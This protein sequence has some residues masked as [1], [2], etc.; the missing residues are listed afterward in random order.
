M[1]RWLKII[2][3]SVLAVAGILIATPIE[4]HPPTSARPS[5][6]SV[7]PQ[8]FVVSLQR[9]LISVD[10]HATTALHGDIESLVKTMQTGKATV[11]GSSIDV[12]GVAT[13]N[14]NWAATLNTFR[15]NLPANVDLA[16]D[17]FVVDESLRIDSLCHKI[18]AA[19][20]DGKI[21]FRQSSSEL[22][23]SSYAALDRLISFARDCR[24]IAIQITGHSDA[25]GSVEF[26]RALSQRRAQAVAD[27]LHRGGISLDRLLVAGRGAEE[28]I[29]DN[30]TAH[31]RGR[32]RRIEFSILPLP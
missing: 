14:G 1:P 17:V 3:L 4:K 6:L 23:R 7:P 21:G 22:R 20:S 18:F 9:G 13:I 11:S 31:G 26:N 10:G 8:A 32:N 2:S 12:R 5:S 25:A 19:V 28:P 16:V 29:A 27:Y 15:N 30:N 24:D